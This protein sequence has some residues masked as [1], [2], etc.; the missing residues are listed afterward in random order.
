MKGSKGSKSQ[1]RRR[2]GRYTMKSE[3]EIRNML[4]VCER[5]VDSLT[6]RREVPIGSRRAIS[7]PKCWQGG[8]CCPEECS[9]RKTL[10]WVL[11]EEEQ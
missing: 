9:T 7:I 10:R 11:G 1:A 5:T 3:S 2:G 4:D 8:F 6:N